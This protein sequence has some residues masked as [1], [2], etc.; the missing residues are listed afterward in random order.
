MRSVGVGGRL[1][2]GNRLQATAS[3]R[4]FMPSP[5][6][7]EVASASQAKPAGSGFEQ[8]QES[9]WCP[10]CGRRLQVQTIEGLR[11]L[12]CSRHGVMNHAVLK[13]PRVEAEVT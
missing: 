13:D 3:G 11:K 5:F 8:P 6:S 9:V 10:I 2:S 1:A 7:Q 4:R 12:V